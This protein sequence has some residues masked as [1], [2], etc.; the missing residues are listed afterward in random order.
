MRGGE[1][2]HQQRS[3][4]PYFENI[5]PSPKTPQIPARALFSGNYLTRSPIDPKEKYFH[6]TPNFSSATHLDTPERGRPHP[7]PARRR[8]FLP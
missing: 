3:D 1:N 8:L 5:F 2:R 4:K 7:F 6:T